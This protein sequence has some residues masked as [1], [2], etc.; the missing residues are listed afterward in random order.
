MQLDM[1]FL[2]TL[3]DKLMPFRT[4]Q[5]QFTSSKLE[6]M[7]GPSATMGPFLFWK[8]SNIES[9][10]TVRASLASIIHL[11]LSVGFNLKR[12]LI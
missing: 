2:W 11:F 8:Q 1:I 7:S 6:E 9:E 10:I 3:T 12:D 4:P 5:L